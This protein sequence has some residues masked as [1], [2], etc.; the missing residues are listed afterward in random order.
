MDT[1]NPAE[2]WRTLTAQDRRV[3][4]ALV[5]GGVTTAKAIRDQLP[6]GGAA[7]SLIGVSARLVELGGL[8]LAVTDGRDY[9]PY[10]AC[11]MPTEAGRKAVAAA[12][13]PRSLGVEA[14]TRVALAK[15]DAFA[16]IREVADGLDKVAV[17]LEQALK[18]AGMADAA[19]LLDR[20]L[21]IWAEIPNPHVA[22]TQLAEWAAEIARAEA[23]AES[24]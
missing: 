21:Q 22:I 7:W 17:A 10:Q 6:D 20:F 23:E 13:E 2:I 4:T 3:L 24:A 12:T 15:A 19:P 5:R 8:G 18:S 11:W 14:D 1:D 16:V 9:P